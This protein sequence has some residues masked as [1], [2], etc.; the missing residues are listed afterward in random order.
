MQVKIGKKA[1]FCMGVRRAL[2]ET[3]QAAQKNRGNI[4][5]FGPL[6]HNTQV[7][8]LLQRRKVGIIQS[9]DEVS[10]GDNVVIRAHGVPPQTLQAIESAG[11]II[12]NATCPHVLRAQRTAQKAVDSGAHVIIVGDRGHAEVTG[13]LGYAGE[14]GFVVENADEVAALPDMTHAWVVAQTTQAY[15]T[16]E[17]VTDAIKQRVP[18]VTVVNTI[19]GS[20]SSRQTEVS[21]LAKEVDVM[22]VVG[23]KHSANTVRLAELVRQAQVPVV[24]IETAEELD[25]DSLKPYRIAGVTA[26]ASTPNWIIEE[27]IE[28]LE[29][30]HTG[31]D[32]FSI[33]AAFLSF[34]VKIHIFLAGGAAALTLAA[35]RMMA[36]PHAGLFPLLSFLYLF[37]M[38]NLNMDLE[39]RHGELIP[40]NRRHIYEKYGR[41]LWFMGLFSAVAGLGLAILEGWTTFALLALSS[42]LGMIY[43]IR[44]LPAHWH[45]K[46]LKDIPGSKNVFFAGA[47][48][49]V[50]VLIPAVAHQRF[51]FPQ[52]LITLVY[53][54]TIALIRSITLDLQETQNDQF[55]GRE[56]IPTLIGPWKIKILGSVIL[57]ICMATLTGFVTVKLAP[58]IFL[59]H[60]STTAYI[61]LYLWLYRQRIFT[62]GVKFESMVDFS[63]YMPLAMVLMSQWMV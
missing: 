59:L 36:I 20:T 2:K 12:R 27:I 9:T 29:Q 18:N 26:G 22:I 8:E 34:F 41:L 43:S 53:T 35:C 32:P 40:P 38:Q 33:L 19:C 60:L 57:L 31:F 56:T 23:G 15:E 47:V 63:L 14:H 37:A 46:R 30:V 49:V 39:H 16:F 10:A 11:G 13:L 55:A 52:L 25:M 48:A 51:P 4:Y 54:A 28:K 50:T 61:A 24:H 5:T 1:G 45:Y 58:G 6:I 44:I 21:S 42:F 62:K 7:V 17:A 3:L